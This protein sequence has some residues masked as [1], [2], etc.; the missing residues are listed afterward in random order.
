MSLGLFWRTVMRRLF[1]T[2]MLLYVDDAQI[3]DAACLGTQAQD[4][5]KELT[6]LAG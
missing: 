2:L 5:F 6:A 1:T 3:L 4:I